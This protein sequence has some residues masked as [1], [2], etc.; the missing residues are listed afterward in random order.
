MAEHIMCGGPRSE[1]RKLLGARQRLLWARAA[2]MVLASVV[3]TPASLAPL[4][5]NEIHQSV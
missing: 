5:Q 1:R 2:D 3:S 4:Q